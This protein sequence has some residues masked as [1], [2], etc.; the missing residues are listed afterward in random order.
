MGTMVI[1]NSDRT[2][3]TLRP[4][5]IKSFFGL[6]QILSARNQPQLDILVCKLHKRLEGLKEYPGSGLE[7][8]SIAN[9]P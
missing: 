9:W 4:K 3:N 8:N 6:D 5:V 1:S 2:L 7:I